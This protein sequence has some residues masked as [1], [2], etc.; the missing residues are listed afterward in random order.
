MRGSAAD[1]ALRTAAA[2]HSPASAP[3]D[4][5]DARGYTARHTEHNQ[6]T[7]TVDV[8]CSKR[9]DTPTYAKYIR[10]VPS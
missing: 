10:C 2:A 7:G 6:H 5:G 9:N 4:L 8:I 1:S 3:S